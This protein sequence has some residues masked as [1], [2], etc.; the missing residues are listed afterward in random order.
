VRAGLV[1][2][3]DDEV[4]IAMLMSDL[5]EDAGYRVLLAHDGREA[6]ELLQ[7][8][9]ADVVITDYMMPRLDG[10]EL[11][12]AIK[13]SPEF[14]HIPIVLTSAVAGDVL[15]RHPGLFASFFQ[16]PFDFQELVATVSKIMRA[17]RGS[18]PQNGG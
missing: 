15:E 9:Q 8:E 14:R 17:G 11:A 3:V 6:L 2:V 18:F 16:K 7:R 12:L 5:L 10:L 13:A 4:L 1:L